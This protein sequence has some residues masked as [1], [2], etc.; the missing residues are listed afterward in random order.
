MD[1]MIEMFT[2]LA[3]KEDTDDNELFQLAS[4][5]CNLR[6]S[7]LKLYLLNVREFFFTQRIVN[8]ASDLPS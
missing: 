8:D 3:G 6:G 1:D 5:D 4:S 7:Q 2:I